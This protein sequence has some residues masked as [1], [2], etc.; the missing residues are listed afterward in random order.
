MPI[1]RRSRS[2][3]PTLNEAFGELRADYNAAK[4]S[5][6]RRRRKGVPSSGAGADYHYAS[7]SDYLRI[8][9]DARDMDRNDAV[10]GQLV[11]RV[12]TNTVQEGIQLDPDTGDKGLDEELWQRWTAWGEDPEACDLAGEMCWHDFEE[13][14]LRQMLVDGDVVFL[15]LRYG[16]LQPIEAHRIRTPRNTSRNVVHGVLLDQHRRRVEYW[17]TRDEVSPLRAV[18]KV[19]DVERYAVRDE[20]GHRQLFHVYNR[21]RFTQTRGVSAFAPIFDSLGMFEDVNFAKMVQQQIV[22]CFAI[23]RMRTPDYIGG[24][25]QQHGERSTETLADGSTRTIEGIAPG[26]EID[27]QVGEKLEGFSP[28][29]PNAEFFQHVKLILTLIGINLGCPLVLVLLD[30]SE[31]NF[32]G[33]RGAVDQARLGFRRNQ[34]QM[35]KR[36]YRPCY[37]WKVRQWLSEDA[38]MRAA[39]AKSKI[40]VFRAKWNPPTW[41]YIEPLKDASADLLRVRNGLISPRRLHAER[42]REWEGLAIEMVEDNGF[43]IRRA[44]KEAAAINAEFPDDAPVHWRECLS[45]PTPDGVQVALNASKDDKETANAA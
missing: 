29:V 45:L 3:G 35:V 34:G 2:E 24:G 38:P 40:N 39:A 41:P 22:S 20:D 26:M 42:G 31:T 10:V 11:D 17:I 25:S 32:S 15:P 14:A 12:V 5:R 30:A 13:L 21:K 28:N 6:Y 1:T 4:A 9:E 37:E 36:L 44:K 33:W 7:E 43:A 16:T 23:F 19:S 8:L 27:G 18:Q